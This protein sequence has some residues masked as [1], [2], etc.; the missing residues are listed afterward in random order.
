MGVTEL[1]R[2]V[3]AGFEEH[4]VPFLLIGGMAV[5]TWIAERLTRDVDI[6]AMIR[7][8]DSARLKAALSACSAHDNG[9]KDNISTRP[10]RESAMPGNSSTSAEP[11]SKKRPGWRLR[12]T[13]ALMARKSSGAR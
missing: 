11:V 9:H 2:K 1:I 5:S 12:S 10:A 7:R 6:V 3:A 4:R 13:A 8:K